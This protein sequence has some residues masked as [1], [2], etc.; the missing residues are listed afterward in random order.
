VRSAWKAAAPIFVGC[1]LAGAMAPVLVP[2]GAVVVGLPMLA[3]IG[4]IRRGRGWRARAG[5]P[6]RFAMHLHRTLGHAARLFVPLAVAGAALSIVPGV[7]TDW[8]A[9]GAGA[10]A[11][12]ALAW[13]AVA[14]LPFAADPSAPSLHAGR[15]LVW[16][17]LV[18]DSGRTRRPAYVLWAACAGVAVALASNHALWWPLSMR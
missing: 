10:G 17:S 7:R 18:G 9:R 12:T 16:R 8:L 2:A 6:L 4:D 13:L 14:R 5:V 15:D 11:V 1:A 3:A